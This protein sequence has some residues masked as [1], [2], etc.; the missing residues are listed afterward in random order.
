MLDPSIDRW[1][2]VV[3]ANRVTQQMAV[4]MDWTATILAAGE[5]N[6]AARYPL[7]GDDPL[8]SLKG[9]SP[10]RD[11]TFFWRIYDQDAVRKGRWKY[12]RDG[13]VRKLFDLSV[14]QREQADLGKKQPDVMQS[15]REEFESW[16]QQMLPRLSLQR[17]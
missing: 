2:G 13:S 11:R 14:D 9:P 10:A 5:T 4:A 7:D 8:P 1:P 16:D 15:L 6:A 3:P 12:L 17:R